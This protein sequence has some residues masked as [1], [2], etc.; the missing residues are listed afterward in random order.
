MAAFQKQN[1]H[2]SLLETEHP[3]KPSN[4]LQDAREMPAKPST[5]S[6]L[7]Q[8]GCCLCQQS[9]ISLP[10]DCGWAGSLASSWYPSIPPGL[11]LLVTASRTHPWRAASPM[12]LPKHCLHNRS[13]LANLHRADGK[14]SPPS[15]SSYPI[16][17]QLL[18]RPSCNPLIQFSQ[19]PK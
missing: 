8:K 4:T 5:C 18:L 1:S 11:Y 15:P 6:W 9:A 16:P 19:A 7:V 2:V 12:S 14:P 13:L 17:A 10:G 3:K